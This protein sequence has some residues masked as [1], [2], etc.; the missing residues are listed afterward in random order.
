MQSLDYTTY[1]S[2][3]TWRYGS[4]EMRTLWSE[5]NKR[6]LW[7]RIWVVLAEAQQ[8]ASLV[9]AEQV[10]DL[11]AK[12]DAIDIERACEIEVEIKHDVMAEIRTFAEQC[13]VGGKILHLGATSLDIEDNADVLRQRD[14]LDIV[15]S[16][17]AIVLE[18]LAWQ[19]DKWADTP[20]NG[21]THL[22]PAEPTTVGHRL[23]LYGWDLLLD[24]TELQRIR[25]SLQGKGIRGAVGT[26]ASFVDLLSAWDTEG[27]GDGPSI[28]AEVALQSAEDMER[29]VMRNLGLIACPI[30]SQT[31]PR[32]Q[33][34]LVM[35]AIAGLAGSLYKLAFDLRILQAPLWGEWAEPVGVNQ[36]SSSA[37]PF[38]RNP[39]HAETINSLARFV[40]SLTRLTWDNAA[41]ALLE[42]TLD[43]AANRNEMLPT[44]FLAIDEILDRSALIVRGL[45]IH[46]RSIDHNLSKYNLFAATERILM[47][48]VKAGGDR[49]QIHEIIRGYCVKA[50]GEVRAE[51][52]NP[53]PSLLMQDAT[54]SS[55]LSRTQLRSLLRASTYVGLAPKRARHVSLLIRQAITGST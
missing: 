32:K 12:V 27:S 28:S 16:K 49:Q 26:S 44:A 51:R 14:S 9:S 2:P 1:L 10:A 15:L 17:L 52:E 42:R 39:V 41:H 35:N 53:L 25:D 45:E 31:Y 50:W 20:T 6:R 33:D 7:R 23:A 43:D 11:H 30:C 47:A 19:I 4:K 24:L 22:Q 38:K 13:P 5:E 37:M 36:V 21:Y 8:R 3:F 48:A 54:L 29:Y 18:Y 40:A 46:E 34:W 55:L